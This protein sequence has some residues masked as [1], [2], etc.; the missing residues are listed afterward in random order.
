[1]RWI[2]F[3]AMLARRMWILFAAIWIMAFDGI[4]KVSELESELASLLTIIVVTDGLCGGRSYH[5]DDPV[6][7]EQT[8]VLSFPIILWR[9]R[10]FR[11][12][13]VGF[14]SGTVFCGRKSFPLYCAVLII[15]WKR[16]EK[17]FLQFCH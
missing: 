7:R 10:P 4:E 2:S 16:R 13:T 15:V 5:P 6:G 1:M 12:E 9:D 11:E 14:E 8:T 17:L 3:G